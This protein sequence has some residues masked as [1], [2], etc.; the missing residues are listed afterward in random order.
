[1][2]TTNLQAPA[3]STLKDKAVLISLSIGGPGLTKT[4]KEASAET[5]TRYDAEEAS[6][7][8]RKTIL[9]KELT[10]GYR[11][12]SARCRKRFYELTLPW[13]DNG[14]RIVSAAKLDDLMAELRKFEGLW[15]I[16]L[17]AFE[18]SL[19]DGAF[20]EGL[21]ALGQLGKRDDMPTIEDIMSKFKF[22]FDVLPIPD[23]SDFRVEL[24]GAAM[25]RVQESAERVL[26]TS[27]VK[28][29]ADI[30][31]RVHTLVEGYAAK[32]GEV[33]DNGK[34]GIFRDTLVENL[35][36]LVALLPDLNILGDPKLEELR[37]DVEKKVASIDPET[38]RGNSDVRKTQ[39]DAADD[40][41]AKMSK[42]GYGVAF[43]SGPTKKEEASA[44]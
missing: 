12:E 35:Q 6:V 18:K 40:I 37:R 5:A 43:G 14:I 28:I 33:R 9:R 32:L 20:E 38:I 15:Q 31:K 17:R 25:K 4:D 21:K 22:E 39:I 27:E 24:S 19:R 2:S 29:A 16:E 7:A 42:G 13:M 1:M 23:K 34:S 30:H 10:D 44:A 3:H 36:D 11:N 41:L 8:V 26:K